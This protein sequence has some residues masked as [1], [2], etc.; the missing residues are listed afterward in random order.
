MTPDQAK[1]RLRQLKAIHAAAR[2]LQL[3]EETYR[4][5]L[6]SLTGKDSAGAMT[7]GERHQVL[8]H[9]RS[10]GAS[11]PERQPQFI[12]ESPEHG[13]IRALWAELH[14]RGVVRDDSTRALLRWI[15]HQG[16]RIDSLAWLPA[17]QCPSVIEAL[18]GW[19]ARTDC[20][21]VARHVPE[22]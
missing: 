6:R 13:K 9:L 17:W 8:Q 5:M 3:D 22:C 16:I 15:N 7:G 18:K 10:R 11:L 14:R 2:E 21:G 1:I 19:M 20:H 4:T 12:K